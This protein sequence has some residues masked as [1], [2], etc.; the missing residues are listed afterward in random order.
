LDPPAVPPKPRRAGLDPPAVPPK[1]RRAGLDPPAVPPKPRRAGLDPPAVPPKPRRAG[2]DPPAVPPKP[3]RAGLDPPAV[4]PK[5]RRAGLDPPAVPPKPRRAG[6]DP[7]LFRRHQDQKLS[8]RDGASHLSLLVQRNLAQRK[9]TPP[10]R[11][12]LTHRVRGAGGIFR[13]GILP[14]RKTPRILAR[15]P[16]GL[17]RRPRRSGGAPNVKSLKSRAT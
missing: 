9:H 5:P 7:P 12:V 3:R 13:G 8:R 14:P 15:R 16:S 17:V 2:L 6:L 11:P 10:A 1:P 4:P